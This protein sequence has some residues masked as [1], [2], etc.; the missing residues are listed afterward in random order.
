MLKAQKKDVNKVKYWAKGAT[1]TYIF[2]LLWVGLI[3]GCNSWGAH[4]EI[5]L[6]CQAYRGMSVVFI[7]GQQAICFTISSEKQMLTVTLPEK[8]Y[9]NRKYNGLC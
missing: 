2:W 5:I 6:H 9:V 1:V 4:K 7:T 3:L 8:K